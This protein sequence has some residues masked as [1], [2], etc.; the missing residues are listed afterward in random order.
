MQITRP[1]AAEV[2]K[3]LIFFDS[4]SKSVPCG[5]LLS[6]SP[7]IRIGRSYL[8]RTH[9]CPPKRSGPSQEILSRKRNLSAIIAMNSL[10]VGLP[11]LL[12]IV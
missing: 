6:F 8:R 7:H 2:S 10:L 11:R 5:T 1:Q 12:W 9:P 3:M 4:L